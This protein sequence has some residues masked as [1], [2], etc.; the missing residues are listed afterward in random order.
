[1][2]T[3]LLLT[4]TH[5][6]LDYDRAAVTH[7]PFDKTECNKD[8]EKCM[9]FC[10]GNELQYSRIKGQPNYRM[11]TRFSE[12]SVPGYT[13]L[14]TISEVIDKGNTFYSCRKVCLNLN[15]CLSAYRTQWKSGYFWCMQKYYDYQ[16]D[17]CE[18]ADTDV[19]WERW[20]QKIVCK[21]EFLSSDY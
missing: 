20:Q 7:I 16:Y 11:L 5:C 19:K 9:K 4:Q 10:G 21:D 3:I 18:N 14:K 2:L 15:S 1:M 13:H 6:A 17:K 8:E 12:G